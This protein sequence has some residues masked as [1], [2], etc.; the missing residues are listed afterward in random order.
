MSMLSLHERVIVSGVTSGRVAARSGLLFVALTMLCTSVA[1]SQTQGLIAKSTDVTVT[2]VMRV[3]LDGTLRTTNDASES[4]SVATGALGFAFRSTNWQFSAQLNIA[5]KQDTIRSSPGRS[6]LLPGTGGISSGVFEAR[7]RLLPSTFKSKLAKD[8]ADRL[9]AR[10]YVSTSAYNWLLPAA[11]DATGNP[12][13]TDSGRPVVANV[14]GYAIGL[15]YKVLDGYIGK[16]SMKIPRLSN[17]YLMQRFLAASLRETCC[18]A[19]TQK[20]DSVSSSPTP[21]LS[22]VLRLG[23]AYST[24]R[25]RVQSYTTIFPA[26]RLQA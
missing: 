12:A 4:G 1:S 8:I 14:T 11:P 19:A 3:F 26:I 25:F 15:S 24:T 6:I 21:G 9:M 16:P 22:P 20:L 5:S 13:P 7:R 2:S 18:S 10:G 23:P 17:L